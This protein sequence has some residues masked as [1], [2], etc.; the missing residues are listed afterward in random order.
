MHSRRVSEKVSIHHN[1][2]YSGD[3][4]ITMTT[5]PEAHNWVEVTVPMS[6]IVEMVTDM[7]RDKAVSFIESTDD[8]GLLISLVNRD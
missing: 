2:D 3:I 1:G 5:G 7:Y 4:K 6:A 8:L